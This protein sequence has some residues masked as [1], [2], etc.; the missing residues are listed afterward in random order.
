MLYNVSNNMG[1]IQNKAKKVRKNT[2]GV[3]DSI[4]YRWS[5]RSMSGEAVEEQTLLALID[6]ARYAPSAF[7]AQPAQFYYSKNGSKSFA[8]LLVLLAPSNQNW[9][10]NASYL[11]ILVS[12][13]SFEH[14]GKPNKTH[15]FD[16]GAA[17]EAFAIEGVKRNLVVH[18][19]SG[20]DYLKA[21]EFLHLGEDY[22]IECMIAVGQPTE[23][24]ENEEVSLRSPLKEIAIK[25]E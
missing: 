13:M 22:N 14:N 16:T 25:L 20:F 10:K 8:Q 4:I 17:W 21:K 11:I 9:C 23:E 3:L 1:T 24:I 2:E 6:A 15:S 5:P 12:K 7:N 19:M 18:G